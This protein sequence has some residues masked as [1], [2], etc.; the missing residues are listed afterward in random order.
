MAPR[1]ALA[2]DRSDTALDD[3]ADDGHAVLATDVSARRGG[4]TTMTRSLM[5]STQTRPGTASGYGV[6][7]EMRSSE[8][9]GECNA[10]RPMRHMFCASAP[11]E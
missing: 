8:Q 11:W 5:V 3:A 9:F 6:A 1:Q 2:T 7:L 4:R 10:G